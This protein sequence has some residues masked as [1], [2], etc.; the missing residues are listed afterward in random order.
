M[1]VTYE[2][3]KIR[4]ALPLKDKI[5][6][7]NVMIREWYE[8]Y[9]GLVYVAFSGGKDSTVLLDLVRRMYPDVPATF[10]NTGLEFPEILAFVRTVKNVE[11]LKP[12][13]TFKEVLDRHGYPVTSKR[14]AQYI[15]EAKSA[16]GYTATKRLRLTG[17]KPDGR[18]SRMG[19]ISKK[20]QYLIDA[21]FKISEKCCDV[22][23]KNPSK[24]YSKETGRMPFTGEMASEGKNREKTY[25]E[26][27]CNA[28]HFKQPKST[29]MAFWTDEDVWAYIEQHGT[30]YSKIYDMG[31]NRTGCVFCMFGVHLEDKKT[32]TNRFKLLYETHPKLHAYC[33]DKLDLRDVL[34]YINVE[35]VEH[36]ISIETILR[37]SKETT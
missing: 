9:G 23:K 14:L 15:R 31:Y 36:Q 12:K 7:T 34:E 1:S 29:P 20:W 32:G 19:M 11:W 10:N 17:I 18:F 37:K 27:G 8:S 3:L 30:P 5:T 33:M 25:L 2:E 35:S 26:N 21:P 24:I 22:M 6:F 28:F 13:I 4:Q 16:H